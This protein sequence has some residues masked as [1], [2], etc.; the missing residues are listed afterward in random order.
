MLAILEIE[1]VTK[2][3]PEQSGNGTLCVFQDVSFQTEAGEFVTMVGHSGC[4][5]STILNIIAGLDK[6]SEGHVM[7]E[8]QRI[9]KPGLDRM[10][11]F[12]S[13]ALIP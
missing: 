5:K 7:L 1:R 10:V 8:G 3:F 9:R 4:G 11:V 2:R 6:A 13:F 12:Q